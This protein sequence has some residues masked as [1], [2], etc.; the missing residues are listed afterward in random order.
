VRVL[1]R[2]GLPLTLSLSKGDGGWRG[3]GCFDRLSTSGVW[4]CFDRL[5]TSGV[6]GCFNKLSTSGVGVACFD[7]PGTGGHGVAW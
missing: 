5:S 2:I 6:W 3:A 4:G 7:R 1:A